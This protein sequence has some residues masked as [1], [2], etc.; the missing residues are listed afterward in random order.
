M[1]F[2][3]ANVILTKVPGTLRTVASFNYLQLLDVNIVSMEMTFGFVYVTIQ[4]TM[5]FGNMLK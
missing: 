2:V 1:F 5:R 4:M 3:Q